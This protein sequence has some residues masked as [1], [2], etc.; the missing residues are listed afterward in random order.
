[1]K[2]LSGTPCIYFVAEDRHIYVEETKLFL[3]V[4]VYI[5]SNPVKHSMLYSS[6]EVKIKIT[7][8]LSKIPHKNKCKLTTIL[9]CLRK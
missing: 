1:M 6:S 7:N 5:N 9:R 3:F 8:F 2:G 4:D